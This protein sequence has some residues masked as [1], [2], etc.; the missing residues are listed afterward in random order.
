MRAFSIAP[1]VAV[2]C[3]ALS[4]AALADDAKPPLQATTGDATVSIAS[5]KTPRLTY[6]FAENPLKPYVQ[7]FCT[8][9]G[10]NLL[11]DNVAD[12]IHHHGLMF[13]VAADGVDF[14]A[15]SSPEKNGKQANRK[16]ETITRK[17]P[18]GQTAAGIRQQID[19]LAPESKTPVLTEQRSVETYDA[20]ALGASLLTWRTE[21]APAT[22]KKSVTLTGSH[23]FGL[24]MRFVQW[25][26]KN[27]RFVYASGEPG[28]VVRGKERVT[29]SKWVA[30]IAS[31]D[32]KTATAALFDHPANP[33]HPAQ[34]FTMP[35]AFAYCSATLNLWKQPLAVEAGKPLVL[36]YGVAFCDGEADRATIEQ[37]YRT[38]LQ[39]TETSQ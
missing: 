36:T 14:W 13:A 25:M 23:Y 21:L 17:L 27:A 37:L 20:A 11:R 33:R 38:W 34:M 16:I 26:D 32:G 10:V 31:A 8:P 5:G 28:P 18:G 19:W 6:R 29:P 7:A 9:S 35:E 2:A 4:A 1:S 24:G 22:D 3:L 30:C 15:E 39:L 12:H